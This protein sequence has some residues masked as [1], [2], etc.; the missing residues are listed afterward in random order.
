MKKEIIQ[1]DNLAGC[2]GGA[3][4]IYRKLIEQKCVLSVY[5]NIDSGLVEIFYKG[6]HDREQFI[7]ELSKKGFPEVGTTTFKHKTL[8]AINSIKGIFF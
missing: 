4:Y 2:L 1:L 3:N 8:A 5:V 6:N 7:S